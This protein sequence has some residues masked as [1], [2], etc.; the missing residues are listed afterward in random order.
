MVPAL[1]RV[2]FE[3]AGAYSAGFRRR[4]RETRRNGAVEALYVIRARGLATAQETFQSGGAVRFSDRLVGRGSHF[5]TLE[6]LPKM[7]VPCQTQP[8]ESK[9]MNGSIVNRMRHMPQTIP[10]TNRSWGIFA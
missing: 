2:R 1:P 6:R 9:G 3:C 5:L 4:V 8:D 7:H 10:Q